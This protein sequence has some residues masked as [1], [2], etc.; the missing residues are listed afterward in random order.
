MNALRSNTIAVRIQNVLI[1]NQD[2]NVNVILGI[3]NTRMAENVKVGF[4]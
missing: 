4:V 3:E 1:P 2:I